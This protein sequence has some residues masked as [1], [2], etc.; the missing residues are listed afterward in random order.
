MI[1]V[2]V[3]SGTILCYHPPTA[4]YARRSRGGQFCQPPAPPALPR[5]PRACGAPVDEVGAPNSFD[6]CGVSWDCVA[7]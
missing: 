1:G 5:V 7:S 3:R 4:A 6:A 2:W